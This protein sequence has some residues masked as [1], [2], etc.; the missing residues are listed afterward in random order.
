MSGRLYSSL[1]KDLIAELA[2]SSSPRI[3]CDQFGNS[4]PIETQI[5]ADKLGATTDDLNVAILELQMKGF[6]QAEVIDCFTDVTPTGWLEI[7]A[8]SDD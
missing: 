8:D 5:L 6:I 3:G 1:A 4:D 7:V 2:L